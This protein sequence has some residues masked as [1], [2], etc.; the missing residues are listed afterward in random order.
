MPRRNPKS[1]ASK[2]R[3][4][5]EN[6]QF[7]KKSSEVVDQL[8]FQMEDYNGD[9][10][11]DEV[12]C[13]DE[14]S[15]ADDL[16]YMPDN[17]K[18]HVALDYIRGQSARTISREKKRRRELADAGAACNNS[19]TN[20]FSLRGSENNE[21]NL[22]PQFDSR[23]YHSSRLST[24]NEALKQYRGEIR[25]K[26]AF[27]DLTSEGVDFLRH[28]CVA[29]Y[30]DQIRSGSSKGQ[31]ALYAAKAVLDNSNA[32]AGRRVQDLGNFF[33]THLR[34]PECHQGRHRKY[35][36]LIADEDIQ[37]QCLDFLE[38]QKK[39]AITTSGFQQFIF[40][41]F[42]MK[43]SL[44]TV[45]RWFKILN[46]K[47]QPVRKGIYHDGHE[48]P[49]VIRDRSAF[50]RE[51]EQLEPLLP[52]IADDSNAEMI[53]NVQENQSKHVLVV[54]DESV[55]YANDG[56][57]M[58]WKEAFESILRKKSL[59]SSIMV[60]EFLCECHGPMKN[61][62]KIIKPG[63]NRDGY[64]T[65]ADVVQ[66]A[67]D[68]VKEFER[69]HPGCV[70][71]FSFD[72][73]QNH[74]SYADDALLVSRLNLS[75]GG[76]NQSIMRDTT[77]GTANT[78]QQMWFW[79]NGIKK[80]KGIRRIL[81]ERGL[82]RDGL[83]KKCK[84]SCSSETCC[85]NSVLENQ[86]DFKEQ[87]SA[88][89]EAVTVTGHKYIL[90]PKFHCE[91][92][93]IELYW[94]EAKRILRG[95]CNFSAKDLDIRV[96]KVLDS[97]PVSLIRRNAQYCYRW[98]DCYRKGLTPLMA[99]YASK[100]YHGHRMIPPKGSQLYVELMKTVENEI[101]REKIKLMR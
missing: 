24:V 88:L 14:E 56:R 11:P 54:H 70:A 75:D 83:K 63:K 58:I 13:F 17:F 46:Y 18:K 101:S 7:Q 29:I 10:D 12:A 100:Q 42:K 61:V 66:Q 92:N 8:L 76:S 4:R 65:G 62:R 1:Q 44:P 94:A 47:F 30:F 97:I 74:C 86:P 38:I 33:Y 23:V 2:N 32:W 37:R 36:L 99:R 81:E 89:E 3:N 16:D 91:L 43:I 5:D 72:Q 51:M 50:L 45:R 79:D 68:A 73:S 31:A 6:G 52:K 90:F 95:E 59:G 15:D 71:V 82:W 39:T 27:E 26:K 41:K 20:Y 40:Q 80:S 19:I 67:R 57:R 21:I 9:S 35:E 98:M 84:N 85:A 53:W 78:V 55:F 93:H 25:N 96:A 64:W 69:L 28:R 87:K 49:D 77:W 34:L 60:S 22:V 48:R